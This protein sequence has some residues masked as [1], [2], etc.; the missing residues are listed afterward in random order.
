MVCYSDNIHIFDEI[1]LYQLNS[2]RPLL[3]IIFVLCSIG[4]TIAQIPT[5]I[6]ND[7]AFYFARKINTPIKLDGIIDEPIWQSAQKAS[8]FQ[9]NSPN[10]RLPATGLTEVMVT[11][12]D[13]YIYVGAKVYNTIK[14]QPYITP[15]LKRDY[16]GE[17]NDALVIVLDTYNDKNNA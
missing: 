17:S 10:D 9:Q 14:N 1:D 15:S 16:R 12:D 3:I 6:V 7:S 4:T 11:Y 8:N 2:N 5:K 13:K